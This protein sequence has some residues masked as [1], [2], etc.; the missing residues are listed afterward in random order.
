MEDLEGEH[1]GSMEVMQEENLEA[2]YLGSM[3]ALPSPAWG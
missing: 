3:M 1:L 2:K